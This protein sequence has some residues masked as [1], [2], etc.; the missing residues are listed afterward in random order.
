MYRI[1]KKI[2]FAVLVVLFTVPF[3]IYAQSGEQGLPFTILHTNDEHSH[4]IP[5]PAVNFHPEREHSARG[6][7][8]RLAG[9]VDFIK[10]KKAETNEPVLVFSGGDI[11]GGPAFGWFP[12]MEGM[13]PELKLFQDIGYDA[14]TIGNH[15]F[16]YGAD[17]FAKYLEAAGYPEA[18]SQTVILGTNTRPP[19]DHPLS[20]MGI[21]THY[22]K[23]LENGLK[24]G[25]FGLLGDDAINKTAEPGPVNFEDPVRSAR[26]AVEQLIQEGADILISVNHS[27]LYEDRLLAQEIPEIDVIVGGHSHT[28]LYE[29]VI[30]GKTVIVQA[31]SYLHYLGVLE[32]E[33][34]PAEQRVRV[35]NNE[36]DTPFLQPLDH[37]VPVHEGIREKVEEY[38]TILNSWVSELTGGIV[39]DITQPVARSEFAITGGRYQRETAIGNYITDAMKMAAENA[40]GKRVDLAV[41]ANGAIRANITPGK[42]EWSVGLISFYDLVMASGLGSGA[43][44]NPGYPLVSFYL[45]EREVRRALEVSVLLS[46]LMDNTYFLQYSGL[47]KIYDPNRAVV[48]TIPFAD[49]PIPSSRAVLSAELEL[50]DGTWRPISRNSE[51]L[52]HVVTD[53]YIAGFLP[54]VGEVVPQLSIEFKNEDG[55][56]LAL[57]DAVIMKNGSQLKLWQALLEYTKSHPPGDD[58]LPVIP[59]IYQDTSG[60]Q[61]MVNTLPLWVWPV[62]GVVLI[63]M[64]VVWVVKKRKG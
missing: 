22:I 27:G 33:W 48:L 52:L 17:V 26:N 8:A 57:E 7:F 36:H 28:T 38:T 25:I 44:G 61:I 30:E 40:L 12:L 1:S 29:P 10:Q 15:E 54:M 60:R 9:A 37:T 63:V 49:T 41:Q 4:L 56:P 55:E 34:L 51:E 21:K 42:E 35:L 32:L 6:G 24:V 19:P 11:L 39:T 13:A 16:D 18:S 46:G 50:D 3:H 45:T 20:Q 62:F 14:I 59:A 5:H 53:R 23:E 43:D 58:G 31:G 2:Q 47:R 64:V